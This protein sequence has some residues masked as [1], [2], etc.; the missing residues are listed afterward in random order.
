[1][2]LLAAP[3]GPGVRFDAGI[4]TGSEVTVHYD[5]MLAKIV[6]WGRDR[7]ESIERMQAAL[8]D[9]VVLGVTTNTARL[10]AIVAHPAF[11]AGDLHTGFLDEHLRDAADQP[12]L[13]NEALAA[14]LAALQQL[15][16]GNGRAKTQAPDP[17]AS[18]GAW[19]IGGAS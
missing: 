17:W 8:R 4:A 14:A 13:P 9:T 12:P 15:P 1:V 19:R 3:E 18:L 5:P 6:T 11:V 10:R 7:M 16:A 2:L